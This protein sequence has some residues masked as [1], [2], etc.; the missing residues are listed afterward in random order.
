MDDSALISSTTEPCYACNTI[1]STNDPFCAGCGYPL[2]GTDFNKNTFLANRDN[3]HIDLDE[4]HKK[5]KRASKSLFYIAGFFAFGLLVTL[6]LNKTAAD[7]LTATI[8]IYLI[9]ILMFVALGFF[10]R[11]KPL[12][13]IVSGLVLYIIIQII[14]FID[15][16][17]TIASGIIVKILIIGYLINGIRSAID[18]EKFKKEH[19]IS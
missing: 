18:I 1:V 17:A 3:I 11:K 5:L 7:L 16:P 2:K 13:S 6:L 9:L 8:I 15:N 10:S 14:N 12:A 4:F 19:N